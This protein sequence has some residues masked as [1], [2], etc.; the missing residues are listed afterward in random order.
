V[1]RDIPYRFHTEGR[2]YERKAKA[3]R[4]N[5]GLD[6]GWNRSEPELDESRALARQRDNRDPISTPCIYGI[7][8]H[9]SGGHERDAEQ[10]ERESRVLPM[11][12]GIVECHKRG[13]RPEPNPSQ[14]E[15][16]AIREDLF[17]RVDTLGL[18]LI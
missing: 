11:P 5:A 6:Y 2:E 17:Q 10:T 1:R 13:N 8:K 15:A 12:T 18:L 4:S 14:S 3:G 9:Q 7:R 16:E